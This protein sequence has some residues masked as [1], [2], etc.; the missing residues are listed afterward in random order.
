MVTRTTVPHTSAPAKKQT[1]LPEAMLLFLR[2]GP[3]GRP[4]HAARATARGN[5]SPLRYPQGH[6]AD[7]G[8]RAEQGTAKG[9][10]GGVSGR[11]R[12]GFGG[13]GVAKLLDRSGDEGG[14]AGQ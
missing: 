11:R 8:G 5:G 4:V 3:S 2:D 6:G 7:G 14:G 13:K 10:R 1:R 12:S 9:A